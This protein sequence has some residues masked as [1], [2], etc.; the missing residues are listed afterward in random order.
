MKQLA[1]TLK[2]DKPDMCSCGK[3]PAQE[4]HPCP[5]R[6]ELCGEGGEYCSCCDECRYQCAMDI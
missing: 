4:E 5:Y 2:S 6:E 1:P 3:N